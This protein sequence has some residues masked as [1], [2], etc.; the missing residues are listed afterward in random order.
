MRAGLLASALFCWLLFG[1]LA[2]AVE[3]GPIFFDAPLLT[4]FASWRSEPLTSAMVALTHL[5]GYVVQ[6]TIGVTVGVGLLIRARPLGVFT[7]TALLGSFALNAGLKLFFAR[8]RPTLVERITEPHG[9]SFPSGHSQSTMAMAL[10]LVILVYHHP[11]ATETQRRL[12]WL[13]LLMPLG[14]GWTRSYLGVHYPTDVIAGWALAAGWVL[15]VLAILRP[16]LQAG[17]RAR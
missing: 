17:A 5:G 15:A 10:T 6:L 11:R 8:P 3:P 12:A 2:W 13:L 14:V 16:R 9:L 4:T 1:G 7:A